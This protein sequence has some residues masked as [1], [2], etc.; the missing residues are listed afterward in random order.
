MDREGRTLVAKSVTVCADAEALARTAAGR[1]RSLKPKTVALS[2]GQTPR[3]TYQLLPRWPHTKY[4]FTDERPDG[5]NH[6]LVRDLLPNLFP[7]S[8]GKEEEY[9]SLLR[10]ELGDGAFDLCFLGVGEDGHTAS[11][12]PG[13]A[14]LEETRRWVM[15]ALQGRMTLTVPL[16]AASQSILVLASGALKAA[17]VQQVFEGACVFPIERVLSAAS[18]VEWILDRDAASRIQA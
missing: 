5:S 3:R 8:P 16:L 15:P 2:G 9:E 12:F 4:F 10:R 14:A 13:S 7:M 1:F 17:I 6:A 18:N 11:L